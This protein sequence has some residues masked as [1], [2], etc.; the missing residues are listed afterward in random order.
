MI[1]VWI[2]MLISLGFGAGYAWRGLIERMHYVDREMLTQD[3]HER[4]LR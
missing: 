2:V 3:E 4:Q 1:W